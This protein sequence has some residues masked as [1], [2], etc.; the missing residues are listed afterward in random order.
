[1]APPVLCG[2]CSI[3]GC[4]NP[5]MSSGQWGW[6][7]ADYLNSLGL[8]PGAQHCKKAA[9]LRKVGKKGE[10]GTP[11]RKRQAGGDVDGPPIGRFIDV[12]VP[13]PPYL[14]DIQEIWGV[15]RACPARVP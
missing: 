4:P 5:S 12:T 3:P 6:V 2:P 9:C 13:R 7:P 8:P 11:G 15:R 1:M 14:Q 10:K